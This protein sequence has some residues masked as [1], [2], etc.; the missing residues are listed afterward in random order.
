MT[1]P[2]SESTGTTRRAQRALEH[3]GG[4]PIRHGQQR[5]HRALPTILK[6]VAA[7]LAVVLVS[8]ASVATYATWNVTNN[9]AAG[10]I[11]ITPDDDSEPPAVGAIVGGFNMLVVG[12]DNDS[13][14]GDQYGFR[15]GTLN[16]VNMLIHVSS[17]HTSATVVS[18]PRDLIV[19]HPE[20]T[21]PMTKVVNSALYAAPLNDAQSRG[22]LACVVKTVAELTGLK[23]PYAAQIS[24]NGVV[25]MTNAIGGVPV[26]LA[27]AINDSDTGLHLKAGTHKLSGQTALEFLRT[28]HGV[29]DSSDLARISSQQIYLS[30]LIKTVKTNGT[31]TDVTK[32]YK[33]AT[34]AS[35]N[36]HLSTSLSSLDTMVSMAQAASSIN[37]DELAFVQYPGSTGNASYP[38]KVVP[39]T[40]L[41]DEIFS[42]IKAD[43][44]VVLADGSIRGGSAVL[45]TA[46]PTATSTTPA[47]ATSTP[48]ATP[49][50]PTATTTAPATT[51]PVTPKPTKTVSGGTG[52]MGNDTACVVGS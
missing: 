34:A 13:S 52:I 28:R 50:T 25:K 30:S 48:T 49:T 37:L 8:G 16:D 51:A 35:K 14:Q 46:T 29:G 38:G 20:C 22:G 47:T 10:G 12:V 4:G 3:N 23:I 2:T 40:V 1:L 17:D 33:L 36:V 19:S 41:A 44:P 15:S 45:S 24:F 39:N 21:N 26:C 5:P 43:K 32:L 31:L 27:T 6:I 18:L 9:L 7:A 42:A 11:D